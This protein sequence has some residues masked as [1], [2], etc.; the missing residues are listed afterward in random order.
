MKNKSVQIIV[1]NWNQKQLSLDCIESLKKTSYKK[2]QIIFVDNASSDGSVG[3]IGKKHPDIEIIQAP[4]NLGYA[5]GNNFGFRSIKRQ[6]DYTIFINNA[7]NFGLSDLHQMRGRVGRSNKKAF[8]YFITPPLSAMNSDSQKRIQA[9]EAFSELGSGIQIAMKDLEIRGAGDLLGGEQSGFINEMGF[10]TYQKIL[11]EAIEEL[12]EKEFK[13]LY[14]EDKN[15][16]EKQYVKSVHIDTDLE[17]YIPDDYV[18]V[19]NER[20]NLYQELNELKNKEALK[21]F[22]NTLIDRFGKLP[23]QVTELMES[24]MLKWVAIELGIERLIIKKGKCI[25]YFVSN[26]E[27]SFYQSP[28]FSNII[29]EVQKSNGSIQLKEKQTANGLR[30]LL[31]VER[32]SRIK[33]L[34]E[35]LQELTTIKVV[36]NS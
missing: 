5:G 14:K 12:K 2:K 35:M 29:H 36:S 28:T 21:V 22:Q 1:L 4:K 31:V 27:S 3:Y 17:I 34:R 15:T 11:A 18:N 6:A 19:V 26:Q 16:S 8:C 9:I 13:N 33:T 23:E 30:L 24:V 20:L 25:G 32:I 10:D 7:N